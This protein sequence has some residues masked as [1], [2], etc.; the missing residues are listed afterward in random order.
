MLLNF[1]IV[2]IF[3]FFYCISYHEW[4]NSMAMNFFIYLYSLLSARVHGRNI[5]LTNVHCVTNY[6]DQYICFAFFLSWDAIL[7]EQVS[8]DIFSL[9]ERLA[10]KFFCIGWFSRSRE[11]GYHTFQSFSRI[12]PFMHATSPSY[13]PLIV[14]RITINTVYAVWIDE[15]LP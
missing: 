10:A 7:L 12:L 5:L 3:F 11:R 14:N 4:N 13:Y 15:R 8:V 6:N 9:W 2:W 1:F